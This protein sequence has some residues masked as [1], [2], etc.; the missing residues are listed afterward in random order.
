MK[1]KKKKVHFNF[2]ELLPFANFDKKFDISKKVGQ[3]SK[4]P[5]ENFKK[6]LFLV[7]FF[8]FFS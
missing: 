7:I 6:N 3:L 4:I 8:A 5:C 2:F 1:I